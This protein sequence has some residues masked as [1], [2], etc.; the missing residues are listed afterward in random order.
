VELGENDIFGSFVQS[1]YQSGS[2]FIKRTLKKVEKI[3]FFYK[4]NPK[5]IDLFYL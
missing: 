1:L 2:G 3:L 4:N 5:Y